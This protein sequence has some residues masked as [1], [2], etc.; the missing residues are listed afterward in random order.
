MQVP[1]PAPRTTL[2]PRSTTPLEAG[3]RP[4]RRG[5]CVTVLTVGMSDFPPRINRPLMGFHIP[6]KHLA[7]IMELLQCVHGLCV[8]QGWKRGSRAWPPCCL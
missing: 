3:A 8:G 5:G 2:V 4:C 7:G 1:R 6:L